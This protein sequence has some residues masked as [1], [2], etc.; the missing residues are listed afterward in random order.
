MY[1]SSK[2]IEEESYDPDHNKYEGNYIDQSFHQ[3]NFFGRFDF[4]PGFEPV[5]SK[6]SS[7]SS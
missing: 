6:S 1:K 7:S 2:T 4:E 3:D 5:L